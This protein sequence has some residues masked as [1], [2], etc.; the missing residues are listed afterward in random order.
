MQRGCRCLGNGVCGYS[1][2][3]RARLLNSAACQAPCPPPRRIMKSRRRTVG[4]SVPPEPRVCTSSTGFSARAVA[5]QVRRSGLPLRRS[6]AAVSWDDGV[7]CAGGIRPPSPA[8][9]TGTQPS[10]DGPRG[11]GILRG[12]SPRSAMYDNQDVGLGRSPKGLGEDLLPDFSQRQRS[13]EAVESACSVL[14]GRDCA[15]LQG[16]QL[17]VR[18]GRGDCP[19][20]RS[21]AGSRSSR[22]DRRSRRRC[23]RRGHGAVQA[24]AGRRPRRRSRVRRSFRRRRPGRDW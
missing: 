20:C 17:G 4:S 12:V 5:A 11:E 10:R 6:A 2:A 22:R 3:V 16:G 15:S 14:R 21:G 18:T 13:G 8:G 24:A 7:G 9:H 19:V 23:R 1:A